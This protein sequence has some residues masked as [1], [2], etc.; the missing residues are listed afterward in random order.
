MFGQLLKSSF[1]TAQ[2]IKEHKHLS[3]SPWSKRVESSRIDINLSSSKNSV[4]KM[5]NSDYKE[6]SENDKL[7]SNNCSRSRVNNFNSNNNYKPIESYT[8]GSTKNSHLSA[9]LY[10]SS[11][12]LLLFFIPLMAGYIS[13]KLSRYLMKMSKSFGIDY[14]KKNKIK[15]PE[16]IGLSAGISFVFSIFISSIF[17]TDKKEYLL[18]F[19][20]SIILNILLGYVDDTM[21]LPW[22]C[23]LLFPILSIIPMI[24]TYSG[25]RSISI[26]FSGVYDLGQFFYFCLVC[27]SIYFTNAIN[28]L[29][30]ING[31]ETGQVLVIS[32]MMAVDR[33][34]FSDSDNALSI[35]L[36][37]SLFSSTLGLFIWNRFPSRCFVGDTFCYFSGC[38]FLCIGLLGGFL[39]TIFLFCT[40]QFI[41]FLISMPQLIKILP[42]PRHRMPGIIELSGTEPE[43]NKEMDQEITQEIE[44]EEKS[45]IN[46][47]IEKKRKDDNEVTKDQNNLNSAMDVMNTSTN[48]IL[49]VPSV[50][51]V[52]KKYILGSAV[53]RNIVYLFTKLRIISCAE[54]KDS[55]TISN[56][57]ILNIVLV[58]KGP[59]K[60]NT[61]FTYYMIIQT[62]IC[63]AVLAIKVMLNTAE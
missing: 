12:K 18:I 40:P 38:S 51:T 16:S 42:C 44:V 14:H 60:E 48:E 2:E 55:Y 10:T 62:A 25:S 30:G 31:I 17:F 8:T 24:V 7:I 35:L 11:T 43:E 59:M 22:S 9:D 54:D 36:C 4:C 20:N 3:N 15:I 32:M 57:T 1:T 39:K 58:I 56:F 19:T 34:I 45:R 50:F 41:N 61:L 46:R 21:E 63:I 26:P 5:I 6:R 23:K 52:S 37:L 13:Y 27:L 49:L 47:M 53:R 28:I 33:C 29:S